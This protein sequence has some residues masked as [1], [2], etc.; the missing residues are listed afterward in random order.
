MRTASE[1]LVVMVKYPLPGVVKTRLAVSVGARRACALYTAFLRDIATRFQK[2]PWQLVWAVEPPGSDL[3]KIVGCPTVQLDQQGGSLGE[4]MLR[5]F[6]TL[7][8]AGAERVVMMGAD[9]PHLGR[10]VVGAAFR[11]LERHDVSLVPSQDGGYCLIGLRQSFDVFT[12]VMMSTPNVFR[13]T[14]ERIAEL[15]LAVD[16]QETSFDIDEFDDVVRLRDEMS[17]GRTDLVETATLLRAWEKEGLL[18]R[19]G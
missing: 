6:E 3:E 10:T 1:V 4:R 9:V 11:A 13:E 14:C 8:G 15:G 7:L 16:V 2:T 12:G 17:A 5:C 19:H 18:P